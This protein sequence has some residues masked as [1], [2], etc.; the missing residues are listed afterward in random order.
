M[1]F[2]IDYV[3]VLGFIKMK[4]PIML[5]IMSMICNQIETSLIALPGNPHSS[6]T[7]RY[8]Q[9]SVTAVPGNSDLTVS[10]TSISCPWYID[11]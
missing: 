8:W 1:L 11:S 2:I 3:L 9:L 10:S 5:L 6:Y 4:Q 7:H